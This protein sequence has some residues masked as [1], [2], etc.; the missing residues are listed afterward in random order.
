MCVT[1]N[2]TCRVVYT[3]Q[4]KLPVSETSTCILLAVFWFYAK[5]SSRPEL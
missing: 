5:K 2:N 4:H 1:I 3:D